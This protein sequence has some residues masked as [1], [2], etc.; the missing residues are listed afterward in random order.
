ML[1]IMN[2]TDMVRLLAEQ[3]LRHY[4]SLDWTDIVTK[5]LA[6]GRCK[7]DENT[8]FRLDSIAEAVMDVILA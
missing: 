6:L 4:A 5:L 1:E 7:D 3:P 2:F 8:N